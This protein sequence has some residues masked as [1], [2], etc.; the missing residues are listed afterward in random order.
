MAEL[1]AFRYAMIG[2]MTFLAI[3][4]VIFLLGDVAKLFGDPPL[5]KS[6]MRYISYGNYRLRS[7]AKRSSDV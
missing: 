5:D 1:S 3:V 6:P 2:I 7:P 4:Y